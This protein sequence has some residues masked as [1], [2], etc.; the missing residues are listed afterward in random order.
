MDHSIKFLTNEE[1]KK[2]SN[3]LKE[4]SIFDLNNGL[5][6]QQVKYFISFRDELKDIYERRFK[7]SKKPVM[8]S[9]LEKLVNNLKTTSSEQIIVCF[10]TIDTYRVIIFM[11]SGMEVILGEIVKDTHFIN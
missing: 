10:I 11:D 2:V 4:F 7:M 3:L 1:F 9:E 8:R 5:V 6:D